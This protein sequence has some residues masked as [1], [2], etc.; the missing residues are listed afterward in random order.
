MSTSHNPALPGQQHDPD[1]NEARDEQTGD[2][3]ERRKR[4]IFWAIPALFLLGML[5]WLF[6]A[7]G[8]QPDAPT[9]LSDLPTVDGTLNVVEADRLVMTAFEPLDGDTE[10][11][12]EIP[13]KYQGNFD[14]AHLRS[15]SSVG[16]PTRIY[17]LEQDGKRLAVYKE[18]APVN[19]GGSQ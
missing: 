18:D 14:V 7:E 6:S 11:E 16:I 3:N 15:H 2:R 17:Y 19:T 4:L 5:I 12:F 13:E 1:L 8:A 10:V 9:N